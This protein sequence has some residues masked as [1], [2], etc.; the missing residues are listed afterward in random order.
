MT[1]AELEE[2]LLDIEIILNNRLLTYIEEEIDY[3]ILTPNSLILGRDVNF[4]D[5]APHESESETIKKR[6]KYI[7]RFEMVACGRVK[8]AQKNTN[9]N[10]KIQN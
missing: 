1:W 10:S 2:V 6:H 3:L 4:P 7:K 8:M 9:F 5:A